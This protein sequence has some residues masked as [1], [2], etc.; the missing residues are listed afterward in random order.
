[1][2]EFLTTLGTTARIE[3]IIAKARERIVLVSPFVNWSRLLYDRLCEADQ[4]GIPI[5][6]V[7][8]KNA[9]HPD[10][11]D[12]LE[13]LGHLSLYYCAN[14]HAKCYFN[15]QELIISSLNLLEYSERNNREMSVV[16]SKHEKVYAEA[17]AEVQ[18]ILKASEL[19]S[20]ESA[21]LVDH[22]VPRAPRQ[23][24]SSFGD[25]RRPT[26]RSRGRADTGG[27]CI[28][29]RDRIPLSREAPLC[30]EDESIW[31]RFGIWDY[32]EKFCH[33]CG[34]EASTCKARPFCEK[35]FWTS[36]SL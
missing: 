1:M 6:F 5:V 36:N 22:P 34:A 2:V 28:R 9:L 10:Q 8:G 14:L 4:R 26:N 30:D 18:L 16:F 25:D 12:L 11:Q 24:S 21:T 23:T 29:C 32:V 20:G 27:Y 3:A 33:Q 7:Y 17:V 31:A 15:E 35:C 19:E 13:R